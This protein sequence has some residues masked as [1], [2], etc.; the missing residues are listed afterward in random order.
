VWASCFSL[1]PVP[2]TFGQLRANLR[3]NKL[4]EQVDALNI[5]AGA[6]SDTLQ[7]TVSKGANDHVR[8]RSD[9]DERTVTVSVE[10]IDTLLS[11]FSRSPSILKIDVEGWEGAVLQGA[12]VTLLQNAPLA[13]IVELCEG[14]RYGFDEEKIDENL[15]EMGFTP[16]LYEPFAENSEPL[17]GDERGGDQ[18]QLLFPGCDN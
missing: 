10:P 3:Q 16:V 1:E 12:E 17:T 2:D 8:T 7:F 5:G 14:N 13:L 6:E 11:R 18:R 9:V 15:Q 4:V